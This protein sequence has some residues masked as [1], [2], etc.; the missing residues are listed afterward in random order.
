[1]R[2]L[3]TILAV[4]AIFTAA[5]YAFVTADKNAKDVADFLQSGT[6]FSYEDKT[7]TILNEKIKL[8]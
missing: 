7:L 6:L 3:F 1:M 8:R 4:I 2:R 5:V